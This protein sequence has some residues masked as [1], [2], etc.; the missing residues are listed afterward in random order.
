MT[1]ACLDDIIYSS[2]N[3]ATIEDE[4]DLE[5]SDS[6]DESSSEDSDFSDCE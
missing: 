6:E 4:E 3:T 2:N 1:H 5:A